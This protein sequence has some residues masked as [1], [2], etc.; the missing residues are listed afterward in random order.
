[1]RVAIASL[2]Q[3]WEDKPANLRRCSELVAHAG[4]LNTDIIVFPE[5]T[6]T[7]FTMNA[8]TVAEPADDSPT[9]EAFKDL[10]RE[11]N[12]HIAFGVV[13]H[14]EHRPQNSLVVVGRTGVEL[15]R[16]AKIH[17]FS[18]ADE[19]QH[20]EA[21]AEL[22][23]VTVARVVIGLTICYDLRFPELYT[24]LAPACAAMLVVANW[25][26]TRLDH[27]NALI[28]ARAIDCQC[29]VV[30]ANRTG[31]DERGT[32]YPRSSQVRDPRG[33]TVEPDHT[34]GELDIYTLD[35]H[36]VTRYRRSF[37][38]LRDRRPELYHQLKPA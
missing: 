18:H 35:P 24:A 13:L 19:D 30:A 1:M 9:V 28:A 23:T 21:G 11:H 29:F 17:P 4:A 2:D 7:G 15:G 8:Q 31:H 10:A 3:R 37:P 27:W 36:I 16:Y 5:M 22:I 26:D 6:L 38:T 32:C 20:Y 34:D 14:G 25:P 12:I 33:N